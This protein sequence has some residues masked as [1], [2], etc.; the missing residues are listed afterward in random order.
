MFLTESVGNVGLEL[1]SKDFSIVLLSKVPRRRGVE[2][3]LL[4]RVDD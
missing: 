4:R 2:V 1:R 3:T